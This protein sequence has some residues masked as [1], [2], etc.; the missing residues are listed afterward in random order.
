MFSGSNI[1]FWLLKVA[2][3]GGNGFLQK[4][5]KIEGSNSFEDIGTSEN[6]FSTP[7]NH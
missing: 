7:G 1:G 6:S 2:G 3:R 5:C 4:E